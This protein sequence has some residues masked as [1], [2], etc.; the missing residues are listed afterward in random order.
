VS[1]H[2]AEPQLRGFVAGTLREDLAADIAEHLDDC[3]SCSRRAEALDPLAAVFATVRDPKP[4]PDLVARILVRLERPERPPAREVA[5]GVGLLA[6]AVGLALASG[7]P[8]AI[9]AEVGVFVD[10]LT[11]LGRG[12]ATGLASF[13]VAVALATL[14]ALAGSVVT[15]RLAVLEPGQG[16]LAP[17][18][19][20]S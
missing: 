14:A 16:L 12:L 8:L 7:S 1:H 4:P 18:R 2:I 6:G 13:P 15:L 3:A 17:A 20:S 10:A 19:R 11:S 5:I 9:A